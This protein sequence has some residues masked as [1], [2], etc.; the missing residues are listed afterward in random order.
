MVYSS[1]DSYFGVQ[2]SALARES[3]RFFQQY[4]CK[5]ILELGCGQGRDALFFASS[6]FKVQAMDSSSVAVLQLKQHTE[7]LGLEGIVKVSQVDLAKNLPQN[8]KG[9]IE[10]VYSNLFLCMPLN[11]EEL[12]RIF[13][14][15]Y[16]LLPAGGLHIFSVRNKSSDKSYG[17]GKEVGR[18]TFEI[19]WFRIRFF[20]IDDIL[21][22]THR[23][24]R[25]Q[26]T[27]AEEDPCSLIMVFSVR[28]SN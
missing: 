28:D 13:D 16:D 22:F 1:D 19:N 25:L 17:C 6:G 12:K 20:T 7:K 8:A 27:E 11:D 5:S 15:A 9:K 23:F 14:F 2:P 18:D 24:K 21:A 26:I 10:A 3:V 4:H